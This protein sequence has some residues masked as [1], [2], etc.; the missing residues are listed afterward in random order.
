MPERFNPLKQERELRRSLNIA[1]T[2]RA[3]DEILR[4]IIQPFARETQEIINDDKFVS[5]VVTDA[6]EKF[7]READKV[8]ETRP[9][10]VYIAFGFVYDVFQ[11]IL[12]DKILYASQSRD[13]QNFVT[14]YD[15]AHGSIETSRRPLEAELVVS[16]SPDSFVIARIRSTAE[17]IEKLGKQVS[18]AIEADVYLALVADMQEMEELLKRDPSGFTVLD[19]YIKQLKENPNRPGFPRRFAPPPVVPEFFIAGAELAAMVYK[20]AYLQLKKNK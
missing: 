4:T 12:E 1:P 13:T 11:R 6:K 10:D 2:P 19:D 17:L 3:I 18:P 7:Y 15:V 20:A 14:W 9:S 8:S 5:S 16:Q